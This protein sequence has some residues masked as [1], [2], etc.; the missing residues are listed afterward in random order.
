MV[1]TARILAGRTESRGYM[2]N[3]EQTGAE[4]DRPPNTSSH[5]QP[6]IQNAIDTV[7]RC[8][9]PG[10]EFT[11]LVDGRG[12]VYLQAWYLEADTLGG[13]VEKQYTRRWFLSPHMNN[14][15]IVQTAFKCIL[16]SMEHRTREWFTYKARAI[17]QP[18]YNVEK[19]W[20]IC[21]EREVRE[22][23]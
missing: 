18:H 3:R 5:T 12:E 2:N 7:S 4:L 6:W 21:E 11:V 23:A 17:F 20:E 9:Y 10:Y 13:D 1:L 8:G 16:T 19:L 14:S 22:K 15:E